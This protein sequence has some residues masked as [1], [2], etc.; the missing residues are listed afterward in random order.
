MKKRV[1]IQSR[2]EITRR[3]AVSV[4][5]KTVVLVTLQ[6]IEE[7]ATIDAKRPKLRTGGS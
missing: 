2:A 7:S 6:Q 3:T 1:D 5:I 4:G